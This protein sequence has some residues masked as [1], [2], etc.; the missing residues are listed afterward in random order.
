[1]SKAEALNKK[2]PG[3]VAAQIE[4]RN[5]LLYA[6]EAQRWPLPEEKKAISDRSLQRLLNIKKHAIMSEQYQTPRYE[7]NSEDPDI[8]VKKLNGHVAGSIY[9]GGVYKIAYSADGKYLASVA[10]DESIRLWDVKTGKTIQTI[11]NG[12]YVS[13]LTYS[14]DGQRIATNFKKI[15]ECGIHTQGN[16]L[17]P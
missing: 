14:P 10:A 9:G 6:L 13:K 2:K 16:C 3:T 7:H 5:A 4:F 17:T 11:K 15:Y 1:M 8:A 12:G